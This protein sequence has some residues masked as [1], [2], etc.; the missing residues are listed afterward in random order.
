MTVHIGKKQVIK[1][2]DS[3]ELCVFCVIISLKEETSKKH[4]RNQI[5]HLFI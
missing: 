2:M 3:S 4:L 1:W 5:L